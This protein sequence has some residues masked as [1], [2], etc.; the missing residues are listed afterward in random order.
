M[1]I[2]SGRRPAPS[3]P[4]KRVLSLFSPRTLS[5]AAA[6]DR[7]GF[8]AGFN[9]AHQP[10]AGAALRA[11]ARGVVAVGRHAAVR[12]SRFSVVLCEHGPQR[13]HPACER[14]G[15]DSVWSCVV[16]AAGL[17]FAFAPSAIATIFCVAI[18]EPAG[19]LSVG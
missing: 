11:Q 7:G 18:S 9:A 16:F 6:D 17:S 1:E 19:L 2:T 10:L 8:A 3:A 12:S 14:H 4:S 13:P 15:F 5:G